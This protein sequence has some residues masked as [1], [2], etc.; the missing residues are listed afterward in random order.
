MELF[1]DHSESLIRSKKSVI[2]VADL[3]A[4]EGLTTV[5]PAGGLIYDISKSLAQHARNY[6]LGRAEARLE[7]FHENF[8]NESMSGEEVKDFINKEFNLD[9]Y[10]AILSSCTQDIENEKV[11]IYANLLKGIIEK[12]VEPNLKRHFITTSKDLTF[13]E[14]CFLKEL[15]IYSNFELM[16]PGGIQY[17]VSTLLSTKD[18]FKNI[19]INKLIQLGFIYSGRSKITSMTKQFIQLIFDKDSL[20]PKSVG[21]NKYSGIKILIIS[22]QL[23]NN[24][25]LKVADN[26]QEILFSNNIKSSISIL[27]DK[28]LMLMGNYSAAALLVDD[29]KIMDM[30]IPS[31]TKFSKHKP[32]IKINISEA[33]IRNSVG[34]VIFSDQLNLDNLEPSSIRL[35][36]LE[37]ITN[38]KI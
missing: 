17:Q 12:K 9:D 14:L 8:L 19:I 29:K 31:L 27:D 11:T 32:L 13:S 38:Y 22:Y 28:F 26:I 30:Y 5:V 1:M 36:I 33:G 7:E 16:T 23:G 18:F 25:H 10:Y 3:L 21:K 37:F 24:T 20:K 2:T 34:D 4:K 35:S 15:Y 6:F